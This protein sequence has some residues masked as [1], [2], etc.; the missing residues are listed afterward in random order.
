MTEQ[1]TIGRLAQAGG[2][3]VE[4]V[5]YYQRRSLLDEPGKPLGGQ[6][7]YAPTAATRIR[8]IKRA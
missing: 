1:F 6:R 8:F 3:N 5:R 4:T 7:Q 2:V